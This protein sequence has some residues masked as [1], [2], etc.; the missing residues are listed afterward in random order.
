MKPRRFQAKLGA[1]LTEG[2][3]PTKNQGSGPGRGWHGNSAGH[4]KAG[5]KGGQATA[6]SRDRSFYE[7]IGREGGRRSSGSFTAGSDRAR[8]AGRRGGQR[9]TRGSTQTQ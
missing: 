3:M 6:R 4:A 1:Q 9:S 2:E 7:N 8:E 5:R